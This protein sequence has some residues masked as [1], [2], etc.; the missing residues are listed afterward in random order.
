MNIQHNLKGKKE[1]V[2]YKDLRGPRTRMAITIFI[3]AN[4]ALFNYIFNLTS[5]D[6]HEI[7]FF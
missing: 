1:R 7:F 6:F 4:V 5:L 2:F 3:D